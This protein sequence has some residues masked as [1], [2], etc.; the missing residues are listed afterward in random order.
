MDSQKALKKDYGQGES[1]RSGVLRCKHFLSS[2]P[3]TKFAIYAIPAILL[4]A[5][6]F[7]IPLA[8]FDW[9]RNLGAMVFVPY[10]A[11]VLAAF[12]EGFDPDSEL[13]RD[14][15]EFS[16]LCRIAS[17]S[18]LFTRTVAL[19][20]VLAVVSVIEHLVIDCFTAG[21]MLST[22]SQSFLFGLTPPTAISVLLW[23]V[24]SSSLRGRRRTTKEGWWRTGVR[25]IASVIST[26]LTF[27]CAFA[28]YLIFLLNFCFAKAGLG[29]S[30]AQWLQSSAASA[31]IGESGSSG[32]FSFVTAL[33]IALALYNTSANL[34]MRVCS[35][36]Q[37]LLNRLLVNRDTLLDALIETT[38]IRSTSIELPETNR[39]FNNIVSIIWW[40]A[41]C[42]GAIFFLVAFCP[43]ALGSTISGWL[44]GCIFDAGISVDL[45]KNE[46]FRIFLG[47]I[48]AGYGAVPVTVMSCVF[49]PQRKPAALIVS[50]QGLLCPR[51]LSTM[52]CFSPQKLWS[53][54]R[55]VTVSGKG[56]SQQLTLT[57]GWYRDK[58]KI[59]TEDLDKTQLN[60]LLCAADEYAGNCRFDA[61]AIEMRTR[62][63]EQLKE[64][65]VLSAE[66]FSS[67]IFSPRKGG[68][69]LADGKYRVVRK[70]SGKA[71]SAVY[72][73]RDARSR[74]VVIKEFVLPT[75]ARQRE[76]MLANFEREF[77]TLRSL[78]HPAI[79]KVLDMFEDGEARYIAI[80]F[81]QGCDLR[82]IVERRGPRAETIVRR[83]A[84]DI[85]K[86][87]QFLHQ[88]E[89]PVLHRDLTPDNLMENLDGD[90]M[91]I[92]FGAAHQF[93]EGVTGTLIGKQCY[94]APEQLRG[95]PS[96]GSDIY[97]FGGTLHFLLTGRDPEAL[98]RSDLN[99]CSGVS[100]QMAAIIS[101]CTDFD[102]TARYGSFA[103]VI[104][105]LEGQEFTS[106]EL[107][108]LLDER[109][110]AQASVELIAE[111]LADAVACAGAVSKSDAESATGE[112]ESGK[113]SAFAGS[114]A[115]GVAT[116][117]TELSAS[118]MDDGCDGEFVNTTIREPAS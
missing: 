97:S 106:R 64:N 86:T 41:F 1:L 12:I 100:P 104:A 115:A 117:A 94:I 75:S 98:T 50:S 71:L 102:E 54:L 59:Y 103:E 82:S 83:W 6:D 56:R 85:A 32:W 21:G 23:A 39:G 11:I 36:F 22:L 112:P 79:A 69:L 80:E 48:C 35:S 74:H 72:L 20:V 63:M 116:V 31:G 15:L 58:V 8:P 10:F 108:A 28:G 99:G 91:L 77:Q 52:M 109:G 111:R 57:F 61:A 40:L 113:A 110:F 90:I 44:Q 76:R 29:P 53:N 67:T 27:T 51:G 68:E 62:L 46:N 92:D 34:A 47:S 70:L 2:H 49:L 101:K 93:M 18:A 43:G 78:E 60:E 105:A 95:K 107:R 14:G 55:S 16:A 38:G 89:T 7:V 96:L 25:A 3:K 87:M 9:Q 118:K 65:P 37:I 88:R 30:V 4:L 17:R 13:W 24:H 42:Y 114:S 5:S 19:I 66:K 81:V 84:L 45:A 26:R 73:A 33:V